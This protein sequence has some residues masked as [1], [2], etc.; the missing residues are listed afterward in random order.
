MPDIA[1]RTKLEAALE[2]GLN[3]AFINARREIREAVYFDGMTYNDLENIPL[4]TWDILRVAVMGVFIDVLGDAYREAATSFAG[5]VSFGLSDADLVEA[6]GAWVRPY[7][8]RAAQAL[9]TSSQRILGR[10]AQRNDANE[11]VSR[12]AF[13][14]LTR[15]VLSASRASTNAVTEVTVAVSAGETFVTDRL[16]SLGAEVDEVWFTQIDER[17]CPICAPR[18]GAVKGDGWYNDPPAH[19]N[20]RCYKGYR[21]RR[22][23]V[24][25]I[26]FDDDAVARR[27]RS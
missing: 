25:V 14:L 9:V 5:A 27:L 2:R 15:R 19:P 13:D 22:N 3:L 16:R 20:C 7:A 4:D 10:E 21:I 1:E 26:L 11:G 18:H 8:A 12:Q 24:Q 17:V 23:G 6:S